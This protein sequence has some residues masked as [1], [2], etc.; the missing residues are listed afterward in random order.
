[1]STVFS[2][3]KKIYL[4]MKYLTQPTH[5]HFI[6]PSNKPE[7]FVSV[8]VFFFSAFRYFLLY[9]TSL[10]NLSLILFLNF[11][12]ISICLIKIFSFFIKNEIRLYPSKFISNIVICEWNVHKF[13]QNLG[14]NEIFKNFVYQKK[15]FRYYYYINIYIVY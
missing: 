5:Y 12:K 2:R 14:I 11:S 7:S 1:M 13:F 3:F 10:L 6:S 8:S 15:A 4:E 9:I